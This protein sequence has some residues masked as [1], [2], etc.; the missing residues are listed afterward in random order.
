MPPF[1]A[2]LLREA[3]F[4]LEGRILDVYARGPHEEALVAD[5]AGLGL[6]GTAF[7]IGRLLHAGGH[8]RRDFGPF[9]TAGKI[10]AP[11][12]HFGTTELDRLV[13]QVPER[14]GKAS[15][16]VVEPFGLNTHDD[17]ALGARPIRAAVASSS[18]NPV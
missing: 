1:Y 14:V 11:A 18:E 4:S 13:K 8:E 3:S 6:A 16:V 2:G 5:T 7:L 10:K 15:A 12:R 9:G 17:Q